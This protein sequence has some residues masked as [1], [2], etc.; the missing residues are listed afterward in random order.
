MVICVTLLSFDGSADG[1]STYVLATY[2]NHSGDSTFALVNN[3]PDGYDLVFGATELD[4][5][6]VPEPATWIG[7]ALAL[8]AVAFA[9]RRRLLS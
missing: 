9:S 8:S 3:M 6:P 1:T 4:L 5:V 7:G 2:A